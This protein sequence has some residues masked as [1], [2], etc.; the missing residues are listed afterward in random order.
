MY[1]D[2]ICVI[3]EL[4]INNENKICYGEFE[5]Y[6][7]YSY[8]YIREDVSCN[9]VIVEYIKLLLKTNDFVDIISILNKPIQFKH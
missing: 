4:K 6:Q 2:Y 5:P 9:E 1:I 3:F 8:K 7:F